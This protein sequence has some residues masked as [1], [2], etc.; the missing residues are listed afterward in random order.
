VGFIGVA[1]E[2]HQAHDWQPASPVY[3]ISA[4]KGNELYAIDGEPAVE[5]Y[6]RFFTVDGNFAPMP[7]TAYSF[8][9]IIEGPDPSRRGL[10]RSLRFFDQPKGGATF[11]ADLRAGDQIRLAIRSP[12]APGW[13]REG[14]LAACAQAEAA[15]LFSCVARSQTLST[16]CRRD[17]SILRETLGK[18]PW[19][20][21]DTFG[22]FAP[23]P[24]GP[25]SESGL[26]QH[27]QNAI[28]A[29]LR[30]GGV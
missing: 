10:C 25:T 4:A 21:C 7:H 9:L 22:E 13:N 2:T 23:P 8:P 17:A 6:R 19:I 28:L 5:W 27:N 18:L 20:G 14:F 26:A 29:F 3:T 16:N 15:I 12:R 1:L 24:N 11:W 30:E